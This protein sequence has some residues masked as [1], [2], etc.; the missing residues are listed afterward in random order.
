MIDWFQL[1]TNAIWIL[2]L[3][4]LLAGL[5]YA[6]YQ[7]AGAKRSFRRQ[8]QMPGFNLVSSLGLLLFCVGLAATGNQSWWKSVVWSLLA[9]AFAWQAWVAIRQR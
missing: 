7:A 6:S 3:A 5:S 8:L 2:G 9:L 4:V 1:L